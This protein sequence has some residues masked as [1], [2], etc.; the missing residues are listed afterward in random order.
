MLSVPFSSLHNFG[1]N[2][3]V[4]MPIITRVYAE[5]LEYLDIFLLLWC[6]GC[7]AV[8]NMFR[9]LQAFVVNTQ[10][11]T[12]SL[13]RRYNKTNHFRHLIS[14]KFLKKNIKLTL[15]KDQNDPFTHLWALFLRDMLESVHFTYTHIVLS[16]K[17]VYLSNNKRKIRRLV[18]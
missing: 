5:Y 4:G 6:S 12:F 1:I 14:E 17:R 10:I 16:R 9:V 3:L 13:S 11:V 2:Y 7:S 15:Q 18:V 8:D